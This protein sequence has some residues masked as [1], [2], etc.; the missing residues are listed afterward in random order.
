MLSE[1]KQTEKQHLVWF[2]LYEIFRIDKF[3]ERESRLVVA[4]DGG[5]GGWWMT[6]NEGFFWG[7]WNVL[8]LD[9]DDGCTTLW[10]FSKPGN[11][12]L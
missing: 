9:S 10:G 6:V 12:V 1:R 4:K 8:K 3:I 2:H 11:C 5:S 7:W